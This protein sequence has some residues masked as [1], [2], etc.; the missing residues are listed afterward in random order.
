MPGEVRLSKQIYALKKRQTRGQWIAEWIVE[1]PDNWYQL[2][3]ADQLLWREYTNEDITRKI[4]E[5]QMEQQPRF[6]GVAEIV[7]TSMHFL[8]PPP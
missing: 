6:P 3:H 8:S 1:N 5:L 7:A 4:A 2:T